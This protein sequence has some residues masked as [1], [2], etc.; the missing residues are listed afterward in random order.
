MWTRRCSPAREKVKVK[1]WKDHGEARGDG[2]EL[3]I[4]QKKKLKRKVEKL[5]VK[6]EVTEF[7][8]QWNRRKS[9]SEKLK[10]SRWS[11]RWRSWAGSRT[12]Q[13]STGDPA[14]RWSWVRSWSVFVRFNFFNF[15]VFCYNLPLLPFRLTLVYNWERPC[16]GQRWQDL[17]RSQVN[18]N[19]LPKFHHSLSFTDY[20]RDLRSIS[21]LS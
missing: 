11:K 2:V 17:P 14:L 4:E 5:T 16:Q 8:R 13:R 9:E 6:Q 7:S 3:A 18:I 15:L 19:I 12:S 20:W 10:S 1:S 21:I